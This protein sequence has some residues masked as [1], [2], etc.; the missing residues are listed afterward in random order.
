LYNY[1][2]KLDKEPWRE[3]AALVRKEVRPGDAI[4]LDAPFIRDVF[5]YYFGA[6]AG[7]Q[8]IAPWSQADIPA[9]LDSVSRI[10]LVQAYALLPSD[11]ASNLRTRIAANRQA[12]ATIPVRGRVE[13][14]PYAYWLPDIRVTC[15]ERLDGTK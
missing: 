7:V 5:K 14:N 6:P 1:Y 8:V 13:P 11:V 12:E 10:I 9:T 3:A 15:F 2:T 4:V